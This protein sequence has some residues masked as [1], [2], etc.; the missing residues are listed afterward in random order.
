MS[1]QSQQQISDA[2][3]ESIGFT[4]VHE[5]GDD[6]TETLATASVSKIGGTVSVYAKADDTTK[7]YVGLE[8]EPVWLWLPI[9]PSVDE[10]KKLYEVYVAP[11]IA[12]DDSDFP[13]GAEA[14]AQTV[15]LREAEGRVGLAAENAKTVKWFIGH[16]DYDDYMVG[17]E[18]SLVFNN[19]LNQNMIYTRPICN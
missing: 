3:F 19:W 15:V 14:I 17:I 5:K 18:N 10:L 4:P 16:A 13:A 6:G 7:L 8:D 12:A 2:D 11:T 1:D 9:D